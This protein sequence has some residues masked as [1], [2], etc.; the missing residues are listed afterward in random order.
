MAKKKLSESVSPLFEKVEMLSKGQKIAICATVFALLIG[1]FVGLSYWG[2]YEQIGVLGKK[3]EDEKRKLK[4]AQKNARELDKYR[5]MMADARE[6]F[7]RVRQALPEREEIPSL[8]ASISQT[9]KDAGLEF[10]LFQP[11]PEIK[12]DFYAEIP[13][14]INVTG[15]YHEVATF[16]SN[17]AN[18]SRIVNIDNIQI[19]P[20]VKETGLTTTCTAI[21]YKFIESAPKNEKKK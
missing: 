7:E 2:K 11:N 6:E 3:L 20:R 9:G 13:V 21:T 8:L 14:A 4:L 16:F 18:M 1:G 15:S 19:K 5:K 12:K 10:L 17:V